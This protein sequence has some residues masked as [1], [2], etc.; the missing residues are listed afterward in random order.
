MASQADPSPDRIDPQSPSEV[1]VA[2]DPTEAPATDL[3]SV[4]PPSPDGDIPDTAPP[5]ITSDQ[6]SA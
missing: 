6:F 2:P 1:P 4:G 3:P 5:E